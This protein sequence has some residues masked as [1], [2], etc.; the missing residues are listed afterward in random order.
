MKA[1]NKDLR[2]NLRDFRKIL[3][4]LICKTFRKNKKLSF[5]KNFMNKHTKKFCEIKNFTLSLK[6]NEKELKKK[7][8]KSK[9]IES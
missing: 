2:N 6:K 3:K 4:Q 9:E 5:E 8:Q 1:L 7:I